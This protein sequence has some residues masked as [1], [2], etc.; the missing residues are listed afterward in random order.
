MHR[1]DRYTL[2]HTRFN[3]TMTPLVHTFF[4]LIIKWLTVIVNCMWFGLPLENACRKCFYLEVNCV[5]GDFFVVYGLDLT[6]NSLIGSI[7]RGCFV[8]L[9][10]VCLLG[11]T[12]FLRVF[13]YC[14]R[15][16]LCCREL[17]YLIKISWKKKFWKWP[18]RGV[19]RK[20]K[21]LRGCKS[22]RKFYRGEN[23]KW[24]ILQGW[25]ALLTLLNAFLLYK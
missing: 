22:N 8:F 1:N 2:C 10:H 24:H 11:S 18:I 14:W 16:Y 6:Q 25:K 7:G 15:V 23:R 5:R 9:F 3:R 20:I 21:I 19:F 12:F 4:N 17:I 13:Y